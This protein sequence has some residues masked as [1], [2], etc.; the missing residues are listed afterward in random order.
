MLRPI[1]GILLFLTGTS[2]DLALAED[3]PPPSAPVA[4]SGKPTIAVL[5][6]KEEGMDS[7]GN[8]QDE[9]Y[10]TVASS[11]FQTRRFELMER[12]QLAEVLG[13]AKFQNAGLVDDASAVAVGKQLGVKFV[14]LGS[15]SGAMNRSR[16]SYESNK[17]TVY[18][19]V[20]PAQAT[21][22]LR[23]VSVETGRIEETFKATGTAKEPNSTRSMSAVMRDL[24]VKLNREVSNKFPL[25]GYIIKVITEREA[26]IDLGRK[27]GVV[28]GDRFLMVEW[29]DDII[30]PITGKTIKGQKTVLSELKVTRTDEETSEVKVAGSK[31]KLKL[32]QVLESAPKKASIWESMKDKGK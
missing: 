8:Q 12:G 29:G 13:E 7:F 20:W 15:Y 18:N 26:M 19:E 2:G 17:G 21:V 24:S 25:N 30:H 10:Q 1:F 4:H 6:L 28:E 27:D 3:A 31:V 11:F 22:S 5:P 14:V 32:G 9:M 23:M 16:E